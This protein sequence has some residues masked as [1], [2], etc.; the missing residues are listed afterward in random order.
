MSLVV[1]SG[2]S[3]IAG[4]KE[5]R[6]TSSQNAQSLRQIRVSLT[7]L[8]QC[9]T[10]GAIAGFIVLTCVLPTLL[11]AGG[12]GLN[13]IIVV[14]QTSTNSLALGNYYAEQ[15]QIPPENILRI[16]WAGANISWTA[17]DY[18]NTLLNPLLA[19]LNSRQL[20]NQADYVVL[21]TDIPFKTMNGSTPNS[22]TAALFYG[23]KPDAKGNSNPY[24]SSEGAF[25][26]AHPTT[27]TGYSFLATM[28][29]GN[30]LA[31][32]KAMID[33]GVCSDA[34]FP[35]LPVILEKTSDAARNV[36]YPQ[37]DNAIFNVNLLNR[38]ILL[39]T[40][41]DGF[42]S[43]L[44]LFGFQTGLP[45]YTVPP[46]AFVPGA[47]A[48]SL[49]SYGGVIFGPNSQTSLLAFIA[50]GA[51]GSYGTVDEPLS[52]TQKFP[53]SQD[54]FYQARGFSLAESYYQSLNAPYLG[55]IV[56]EPLAAPFAQS[57]KV[58]WLNP[59]TNAVVSGIVTISNN[60]FASRPLQKMD[61]FVDG[62]F[63]QTVT[64]IPPR[65]GNILTVNLEG[66]PVSYTV[67]TN[68]TL[69]SVVTGLAARIN[70]PWLTNITKIAAFAKGDRI[71]LRSMSSNYLR[72]P[73]YYVDGSATN[74]TSSSYR[75]D[76][77][78][79]PDTP[80]FNSLDF[81]VDTGASLRVETVPGIPCVI[82]AS[83]NLMDWTPI[84]TNAFGGEIQIV[85]PTAVTY[86]YRFYRLIG[87]D[88][89][90]GLSL[91]PANG[92]AMNIHVQTQTAL[93][94]VLEASTNLL[95]WTVIA[96]NAAGGSID[97]VEDSATYARRFYR[98]AAVLPVLPPA[99]LSVVSNTI[100]GGNLV[101]VANPA[102]AYALRTTTNG[103]QWTVILTNTVLTGGEVVAGSA[104]GSADA[105]TTFVSAAQPLFMDSPAL[106][107]RT[108]SFDGTMHTNS[109]LQLTVTKTNG[110]A[111][112]FGVTNQS[113]PINVAALTTQMLNLISAEPGLQSPDG[114]FWADYA[115]DVFGAPSFHFNARSPGLLAAN[116]KIRVT[117]S[118]DI[119]LS[120]GGVTTLNQ[121]L[122]DLQPRSHLYLTTGL[123]TLNGTL[124]LDTTTLADGYHDLM[125][126]AYEGS[127]IA[128]QTRGTLPIR[129]QN[130][131]LTATLTSSDLSDTN[132]VQ[133]IYHL[134]VI[135][136]TNTV[137]TITLYS[138]GG[139]LASASNQPS[140]T[141][142]I[143]GSTLGAG[144]HRFYALVQTS[145]GLQYRT[146]TKWTRLLSVP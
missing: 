47:M 67:P 43:T 29:T 133:G 7:L 108:Y 114:I 17:S 31:E 120:P 4:D 90:P 50:A 16:S 56:G 88:M 144:L 111:L 12:S 24:A 95:D 30:S 132:S 109:W 93:A 98:A 112:V 3:S 6:L 129:I 57:G 110:T 115:V 104:I 80:R 84:T 142:S 135:A 65:P 128:T 39:R 125:A 21:S 145:D 48:D 130:T 18:T 124:L 81:D 55:L 105:L 91:M 44:P 63:F 117:A 146:D 99:T 28:L 123:S 53:N 119:S 5:T 37:F 70:T 45:N 126:V 131:P 136:N 38:S 69:S 54:Y 68:A 72:D 89:T 8:L 141:F 35:G 113:P 127:S 41:S 49:T 107:W 116:I 122:S 10:R 78:P 76:Y 52:D 103:T 11:H 97:L 74:T 102:R 139:P 75:V 94:C 62:K 32:A 101:S 138:T 134:Q 66:Y 2:R 42:P 46:N 15:R 140:A 22:T 100:S 86:P 26:T 9:R 61:L 33:Q 96:T 51:A 71:E 1:R 77:A 19:M 143:D 58:K 118:S 23:L 13:T 36:R 79:F 25:R 137:S 106:G 27:V 59:A 85:D 20:T 92:T 83:T 87:P 121:N 60:A 82:Q 14:N 40:N 34:T 73:F 64:N